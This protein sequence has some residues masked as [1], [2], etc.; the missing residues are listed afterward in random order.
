[1]NLPKP[2]MLHMALTTDVQWN[3]ESNA[4]GYSQMEQE[5]EE[6]EE[7]SFKFLIF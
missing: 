1:M 5:G 4:P 7:E 2:N 6:E 3:P